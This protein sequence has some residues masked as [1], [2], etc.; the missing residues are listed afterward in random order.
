LR[1]F[2]YSLS[3]FLPPSPSLRKTISYGSEATILWYWGP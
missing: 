1:A 2:S 3:P